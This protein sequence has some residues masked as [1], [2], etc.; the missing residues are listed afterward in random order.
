MPSKVW[1]FTYPFPNLNALTADVWEMDKYFHL[2]LH[3]GCNYNFIIWKK[4]GY[5]KQVP[6]GRCNPFGADNN[7]KVLQEA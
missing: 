3:K 7:V 1:N 2:R 5:V 4:D 6:A